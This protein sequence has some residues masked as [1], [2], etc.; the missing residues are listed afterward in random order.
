MRIL[1]LGLSVTGFV[2]IGVLSHLYL[3]TQLGELDLRRAS[4][5]SVS[6]DFANASG[7]APGSVVE[8]AG[9]QVG[10]VI[11]ITLIDTRSRVS[12]RLPDDVRLPDDSARREDSRNRIT[13]GSPRA[14]GRLHRA[15]R[16]EGDRYTERPA[17]PQQ[18]RLEHS[19][20]L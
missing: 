11:T 1:R 18:G 15:P 4:E 12:I 14:D 20:A 13:V 19:F 16:K 3:F 7:L 9:V 5:Y 8:L 2:L 6:A 10:Q 17:A